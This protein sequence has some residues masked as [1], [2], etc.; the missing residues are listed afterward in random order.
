MQNWERETADYM[1]RKAADWVAGEVGCLTEQNR[2]GKGNSH[3]ET[4]H[5]VPSNSSLN[6]NPKHRLNHSISENLPK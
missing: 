5:S 6:C 2:I 4:R 1:H 3:P